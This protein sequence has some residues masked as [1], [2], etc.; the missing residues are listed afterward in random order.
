MAKSIKLMLGLLVFVILLGSNI[1]QSDAATLLPNMN[2]KM[3]GSAV[4][5]YD[6][7]ITGYYKF[8]N[9][10]FGYSIDFPQNFNNGFLPGNSDGATFK[11]FDGSAS[12]SVWGGHNSTKCIEHGD[13]DTV[14]SKKR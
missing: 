8:I 3:S 7:E 9:G 14:S 1:S 10:R 13:R 12:L 6:S 4:K 5:V 2:N 11:T